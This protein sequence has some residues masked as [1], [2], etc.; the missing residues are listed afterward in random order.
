LA[1]QIDQIGHDSNHDLIAG[2]LGDH[3]GKRLVMRL[4]SFFFE[5]LVK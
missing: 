2:R 3:E 4:P 5:S 1:Q